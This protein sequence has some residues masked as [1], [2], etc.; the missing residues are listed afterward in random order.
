MKK[1]LPII[2]WL[3]TGCLLVYMMVIIGGMTR[4]THSGLSMVEWKP[5]GSLPPMN[6]EEWMI[7]FNKY[8]ES[9]EYKL[10]NYNF[11]LDDFK[12][13]FW[14]EYIHRFLGRV[15]GVVFLIP[16]F[17]FLIRKKFPE[18]F[19]RK[20]LL[21]LLIGALQGFVGWFMVKSGLQK[22]PHV[23]HYRLATHLMTALTAFGFT[24]WFAL[25]L[26]YKD[27]DTTRQPHLKSL[28]IVFFILVLIQIVYGAFVAGLKAGYLYP[29]Y[30]KMGDYWIAPEVFSMDSLWQNLAENPAGVQFVHRCIALVLVLFFGFLYYRSRQLPLSAVQQKSVTWIAI[31]IICQFTLGILT[32]LFGVPVF[33]AAAHQTGAFFLF[34]STLFLIHR[35]R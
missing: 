17:Y 21:L 6:T 35:L 25:D 19:L 27:K 16:F 24:F 5:T 12:S 29:T 13:I 33:I 22:N 11:T 31:I 8:K 3:F 9:P 23:S 15:I 34:A 14:W 20:M 32:V 2:I 18:G 7:Q 4:L 10:I 28:S 1:D 26:L 30:P